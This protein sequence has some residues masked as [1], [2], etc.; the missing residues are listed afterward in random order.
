[1]SR[2]FYAAYDELFGH[3]LESVDVEVLNTKEDLVKGEDAVVATAL[4]MLE[5]KK[6][7]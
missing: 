7:R 3:H 6:S 1:M 5:E 2:R 4:R